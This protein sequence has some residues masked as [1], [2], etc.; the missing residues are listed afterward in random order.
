M[1][2][3]YT[4]GVPSPRFSF[5]ASPSPASQIRQIDDL[6]GPAG[7]LEAVLNTGAADAPLAAVLAHPYPPAGGSLHNKVVYHAMKTF[8]ALG[9]PSIRF[10]FRGV[11]RSAGTFDHGIGEQDDVAAAIEWA[12]THLGLPIVF[13]GFSFGSYVGLRATRYDARVVGR[14]GLG[15]PVRAH[16]RD[17]TYEFLPECPGPL[18]FISGDTDEFS[19]VGALERVLA[20]LIASH[21]ATII[22]GADHFFAGTPAS[23]SPKLSA[24]QA[25]LGQWLVDEFAARTD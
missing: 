18:L 21:R 24:M 2:L 25:A 12:H 4:E 13:V 7:P 23:P 19:P 16:Y 1:P 3:H 20:T 5:P 6:I 9:L 11:G 15:L 8:S 14:V 10:N 22:P 17:Y